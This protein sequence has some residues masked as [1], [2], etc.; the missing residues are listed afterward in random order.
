MSL[1]TRRRAVQ[2]AGLGAASLLLPVS[3][4]GKARSLK[5]GVLSDMSGP[6]A[7]ATGPG[8][9][10][11]A[12]FAIEDFVKQHPDIGV[13]LV[14]ADMLLKPAVGASIARSWYDQSGVDAIF[15][16]PQSAVALAVGSIA[17]AKDKLVVF[18]SA[19][20]ADLS[21]KSCTPNQLH[22]TFDLWANANGTV[23]GLVGE[24]A[25]TWYFVLPDYVSGHAMT[26]DAVTALR[27]LGGRELGSTTYPFPGTTDF[28]AQLL[29]AKTSGAKVICLANAGDD[30]ANCIK[31]AFEFGI[32]QSGVRLACLVMQ[33][34]IVKSVGL[35]TAQGLVCTMPWV[36]NMNAA[37][38]AFAERFTPLYHGARPNFYHAG[39]YSA[40][41]HYLK[42]AAMLGVDKAKA[43]G[44]AVADQMKALPVDD[45]YYQG[46]VRADGKFVH[47]MYLWQTK[48]PAESTG[49]W[50]FFK[51]LHTIPPDRAFKPLA[52]SGCPLVKS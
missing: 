36:W 30:T 4:R 3:A 17:K 45:P 35:A 2:G 33:D 10:I 16:I 47:N 50:D 26:D 27:K 29:K 46:Q 14:S 43:S 31:Q 41:T 18:T 24:G 38:R 6:Y 1:L 20:V 25:D 42:A 21:G 12:R 52:E 15:D 7:E 39:I 48:T 32:P 11:A 51:L 13:E 37:A 9:V 44:R 8:D 5:I 23:G 28:S 40:V 34:Y 49:P 22:W 19:G